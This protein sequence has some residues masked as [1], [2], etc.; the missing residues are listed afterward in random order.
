MLEIGQE[1]LLYVTPFRLKEVSAAPTGGEIIP[2]VVS[3]YAKDKS[4]TSA[5]Y[6]KD[7]AGSEREVAPPNTVTG[8]GTATRVA[9]WSTS[10]VLSSNANLYWDNTNS[11]LSIFKG[12]SPV[13]RL[14]IAT[15]TG[16]F[17]IM[18]DS[19]TT[20]AAPTI[21]GR[22]YRTSLA[23]PSAVLANDQL[24]HLSGGGH[25]GSAYQTNKGS[26]IVKAGE[27]WSGTANGTY[28]SLE[29]TANT[30]T[31]R[32]ERARLDNLGTFIIG[33]GAVQSD[34]SGNAIETHPPSGSSGGSAVYCLG[35]GSGS[36][37]NFQG[38]S[39]RGTSGS[40][41]ALGADDV[42]ASFTA[43]GYGTTAYAGAFRAAMQM[44]AGEA[45]TDTAHGT[46]IKFS[47][48][49][50]LSTTAAERFRIGPSGQW[51]IGGA[52][53]WNCWSIF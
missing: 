21:G 27:N 22:S 37:G 43:R 31:T 16:I 44:Y 12:T 10:S 23:S 36:A 7:D 24:M 30:T 51:G 2:N 46:Y 3:F 42:I 9:F 13:G 33:G 11:L 15:D 19:L 17:A 40:P 52:D 41:S 5:L 50:L 25:D 48:T 49:P 1:W 34:L 35:F 45:W 53:I 6:M 26:L 8:T 20:S 32:N 47:T 38:R 29:V 39:A 4:G 14:H 28:I 18:I